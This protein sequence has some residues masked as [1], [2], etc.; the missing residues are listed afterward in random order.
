MN[1]HLKNQ[2]IYE[3][4]DRRDLLKEPTSSPLS[5]FIQEGPKVAIACIILIEPDSLARLLAF[6]LLLAYGA[7]FW[8]HWG[9]W[10]SVHFR[11][12]VLTVD[13]QASRWWQ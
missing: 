3:E 12:F 1:H 13:Y 10:S 6:R 9:G 8:Y 11:A 4:G 5:L 2:P 7:C